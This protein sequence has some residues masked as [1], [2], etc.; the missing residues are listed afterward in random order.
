[1]NGTKPCISYIDIGSTDSQQLFIPRQPRTGEID[2]RISQ[3]ELG[4]VEGRHGRGGSSLRL[5]GMRSR[6]VDKSKV[7]PAM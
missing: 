2:L 4:T 7:I 6:R 5:A 1:M 3:L